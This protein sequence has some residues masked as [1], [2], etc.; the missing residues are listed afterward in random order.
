MDYAI[1]NNGFTSSDDVDMPENYIRIRNA[2]FS[3]LNR[4]SHCLPYGYTQ[5]KNMGAICV[6]VI[7]IIIVII[8][9]L[10]LFFGKIYPSRIDLQ[11]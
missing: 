5:K 11:V 7:L 2:T 6:I 10:Y 8:I 9:L 4:S 1:Y 3:P